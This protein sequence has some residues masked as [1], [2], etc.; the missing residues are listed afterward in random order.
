[1]SLR[2]AGGYFWICVFALW[3]V[4][5]AYTRYFLLSGAN[6]L[7]G[8]LVVMYPYPDGKMNCVV[9]DTTREYNTVPSCD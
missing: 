6:L 7:E 2:G 4:A 3:A 9:E 5:M 1:M 8:V